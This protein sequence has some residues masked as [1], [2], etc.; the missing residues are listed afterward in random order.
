M[1]WHLCL[2]GCVSLFTLAVSIEVNIIGMRVTKFT[3]QRN[4]RF[5]KLNSM[6]PPLHIVCWKKF[7]SRS[8][9]GKI[10]SVYWSYVPKFRSSLLL[11]IS[12]IKQWGQ[13]TSLLNSIVWT[14]TKVLQQLAKSLSLS[15]WILSQYQYSFR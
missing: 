10:R 6:V 15:T 14:S 11:F 4:N 13:I 9:F 12:Y 5:D 1:K 3:F 8:D 2:L 7:F